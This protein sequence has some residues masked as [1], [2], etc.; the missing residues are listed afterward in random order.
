MGKRTAGTCYFK[1]AGK[2][3]EITGGVE[4]PLGD[5]TRET[6]KPGY[7][8]EKEKTPYV[9]VDALF[10]PDFPID[11]I[12][13]GTDMTITVDFA[14]GKTYVLSGA[15]LVGDTSTTGDDGKTALTFEGRKGSWQ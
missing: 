4:A 11:D 15:Y 13:N 7:Y 8:S 9:K 14:N 10:T 3:L 1:V 6:I 2:Q 5:S 12:V